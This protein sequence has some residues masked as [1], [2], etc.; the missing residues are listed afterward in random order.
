MTE[1]FP[2]FAHF[3]SLPPSAALTSLR[4]TGKQCLVAHDIYLLVNKLILKVCE[5]G[6]SFSTTTSCIASAPLA[7]HSGRSSVSKKVPGTGSIQ[8]RASMIA[9]FNWPAAPEQHSQHGRRC[10]PCQ[11]K[12]AQACDF[13]ALS[14]N[15]WHKRK[16]SPDPQPIPYELRRHSWR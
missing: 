3:D 4:T 8:H 5:A 14:Q 15:N 10:Y 9:A 2:D 13:S 12:R 11:N 16:E 6:K 1:Y 7:W